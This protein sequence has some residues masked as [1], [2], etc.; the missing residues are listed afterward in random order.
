[1]NKPCIFCGEEIHP[2]RLK[3]LPLTK[4]C[5][6]CSKTGSKKAVTVSLGEGDH[7]YNDIVILN[8]D[9]YEKY[10]NLL[11]NKNKSDHQL[12]EVLDLDKD[13]KNLSLKDA[14]DDSSFIP[15][16]NE[17]NNNEDE[18]ERDEEDDEKEIDEDIDPYM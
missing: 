14:D 9:E 6:N 8:E 11:N 17:K 12:L 16:I 10:V 15:E 18:N 2:M 5:V 4:T 7:N 3:A 13:D 1:M